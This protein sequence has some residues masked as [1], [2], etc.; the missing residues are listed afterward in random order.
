MTERLKA[1]S[2]AGVSIWL[3]DLS[4]ER[5]ETGNL[6]DL[7]KE[8]SVVGRDHQPDD[9]RGGD[10]RRRA[11]R[12]AGRASWS[13]TAPTTDEVIFELTT[14]RRP[15]RLRRARPGVR[16]HRRLDGR[17]SIEVAPDLAHD[18]DATIASARELWR[19]VD[20]PNLF[21]KIPATTEG[22]PAITAA[23][24]EGISVNVT[25]IFG[26][27]RYREVMDAYLAGLEQA[28]RRRPGPLHDPLG[29][30]V[31]RLPRR[32]RDRQAAR[33]DRHRRGAGA[34]RQGRGRQRPAGLRGVR[35]GLRGRPLAH[36]R[37]GRR[38]HRSGRCGRR[39]ASRTPTTPTRCTSPSWWSP[40]PSTR[41]RRRPWRRSPT[42]A[43]STATR[44]PGRYDDAQQV[45]D[46]LAAVGIDYDDVIATCS[47]RR[48]ST[49]S[50]SPGT[51]CS[52]PSRARWSGPRDD[53][54]LG[55]PSA[56]RR[57]RRSSCSSATP[58]SGVR[59]A[60]EQLVADKVA[61][62]IAAQDATLWGRRRRGGGR[63]AAGLG[64]ALRV[65]PRRW[66]PRSRRS[67]CELREQGVSHVVLCGMGG[68]SLAPEVICATAGVELTV[69][70]S[71][72]PD[73]VRAATRG[74]ARR[75]RRR[76]VQQVRRHGR[77]RQPAARLRE[78]V[79]RRRDRPRRADRRRHRPRLAAR[80]V[81]PG[82]R[83]PGLPRRPERRRPL[84]RADRVRAGAQRPGR[85][86]H[87]RACSTR[88]RRSAG[89][90]GRLRRQP[91][92]S[93]SGALLGAANGAGVDKLV[94]ADAGA[95]YAGLGDWAEQLI[96]ESTGKDGKGILPGRRR[97][98]ATPPTS[99]RAPPDAVLA[100][101]R[102]RRRGRTDAGLGLARPRSTARSAPRCCCGSTPPPSPA[103]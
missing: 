11:L 93:G 65:V 4:R 91:R 3:D 90:R 23:I 81:G 72:D 52:R 59:R 40:T 62:R 34:A 8:K 69:L 37:R 26:L 96:A 41:C 83:L 7:V 39:P 75:D 95:A 19:A 14:E 86:R 16:R 87:R 100:T 88:P 22:L 92:R 80:G 64:G 12:R 49:S 21:I 68:S 48:A 79:R 73:F 70:D 60:V 17:V 55:T 9:L 33:R 103:G 61:S 24:A 53:R 5:I 15:R 1:L 38:Q 51:S 66:S 42:T 77:D 13:P 30:V 2:D 36:A 76:G 82:G 54:T 102:P 98:V 67:A 35:G 74:P 57:T 63:Q 31:L 47:S 43:R 99:P 45:I 32:H 50:R 94:L 28:P 29:G 97:A 84:L 58:T 85:R 10:L 78:G 20:R 18:T 101:L 27:D 44:S 25:L 6:A 71:S 89:P 46:D 56:A